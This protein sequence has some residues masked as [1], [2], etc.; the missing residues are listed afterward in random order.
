MT[1]RG[2]V[3]AMGLLALLASPAQADWFST[4]YLG[5]GMTT[6]QC[7][8]RSL[9]TLQA[10]ALQSDSVNASVTDSAWSAQAHDLAP[11]GID[12]QL[13]C[14]YNDGIVVAV[15][16]VV[17]GA[18]SYVGSD[19][20]GEAIIAV[21]EATPVPGAQA[22]APAPAPSTAPAPDPAPEPAPAPAANK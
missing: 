8:A 22:A 20:Y 19:A 3:A 16:M 9:A 5:S 10:Y 18:N 21:W 13:L 7:V 15:L 6:E 1:A 11:G 2:G 14:P 17:H 4:S 12:V